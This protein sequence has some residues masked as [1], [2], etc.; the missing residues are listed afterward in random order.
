MV[1]RIFTGLRV[2]VALPQDIPRAGTIDAA[3]FERARFMM[4][5]IMAVTMIDMSADDFARFARG[6][7]TKP[8]EERGF[9][10]AYASA[11][12]FGEKRD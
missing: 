4:G 6:K 8:H 9:L 1:S 12:Y 7:K 3:F 5:R 10:S 2:K 11:K